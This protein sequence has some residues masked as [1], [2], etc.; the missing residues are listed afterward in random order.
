M[1]AAFD[2]EP[3]FAPRQCAECNERDDLC[4]LGQKNYCPKHF[5]EAIA[6]LDLKE[7]DKQD[8]TAA[9]EQ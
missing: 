8:N 5:R 3:E 6:D 9:W 2:Q 7:Q 1:S 4:P